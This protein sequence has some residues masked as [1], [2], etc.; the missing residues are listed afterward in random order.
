MKDGEAEFRPYRDAA[1]FAILAGVALAGL[2]IGLLASRRGR[3]EE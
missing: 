1:D 2:V 3:G